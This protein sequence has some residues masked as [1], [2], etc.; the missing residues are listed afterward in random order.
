VNIRNN[1]FSQEFA[2]P[3]D[4]RAPRPGFGDPEREWQHSVALEASGIDS[5]GL[6]RAGGIRSNRLFT[7]DAGIVPCQAG[8][9][10]N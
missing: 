1:A 3:L 4:W 5:G 2:I 8:H 9:A 6:N 7:A 10:Q